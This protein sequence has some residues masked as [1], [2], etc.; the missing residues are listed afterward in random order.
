MA[1]SKK[2][3]LEEF[4]LVTKGNKEKIL[5]LSG[6]ILVTKGNKEK[7]FSLGVLRLLLFFPPKIRRILA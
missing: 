2:A 7:I 5:S 4:I 3:I 1:R 6:F